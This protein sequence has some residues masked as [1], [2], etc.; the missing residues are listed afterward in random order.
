MNIKK[1]VGVIGAGHVGSMVAFILATEGFCEEVVVK[2]P[3]V[4][5]ARGIALDIGQ[6]A[7]ASRSQVIVRAAEKP[8]DMRD[9]SVIVV[10]A[11]S[12]RKPGMSRND[13]LLG[14]ARVIRNVLDE[15]K[16]YIQESVIIMVSNPLDAMVY[17]AIKESGLSRSR[18]VGM[19]GVLDSGRMASFIFEK[20]GY[21]SDQIIASVMGGHGDDMVPL[22]RYSSVAGVPIA[23]LLSPEEIEVIIERTRH[24]G[25]EIVSHLQRGSAYFAPAR[26]TAVMVDAILRDSKQIFPCAVLLEGEYGY[27]GVVGGVPVKLGS[28]GVDQIIELS[29]L[30]EERELFARSVDSVQV[31][32]NTLHAEKFFLSPQ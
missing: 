27:T 23:E 30:K 15:I 26:A 17:T 1:R 14:N 7:I 10:C 12:P 28:Q 31:L 20:L 16:D 6:A 21:G 11:G 18:V 24:A 22:P 2:D 19:A 32:I 25:A 4:G 3:N 9:C 8:E 29:L 13:L 5:P